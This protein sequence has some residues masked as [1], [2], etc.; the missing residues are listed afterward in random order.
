MNPDSISILMQQHSALLLLT[1]SGDK[2]YLKAA[3]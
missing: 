2:L 3:E 1:V